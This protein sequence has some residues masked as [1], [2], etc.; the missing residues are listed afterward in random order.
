MTLRLEEGRR[1]AL[2]HDGMVPDGPQPGGVQHRPRLQLRLLP[3]VPALLAGGQT[4]A[5]A[6][7]NALVVRVAAQRGHT[8]VL[9]P[10]AAVAA[11]VVVQLHSLVY[12]GLHTPGRTQH[13][14]SPPAASP[15]TSGCGW[16]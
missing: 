4:E 3:A 16:G 5:V 13:V 7:L 9:T 8:V 1:L 15:L 11:G 2:C 12:A 10:S 14:T 6:V